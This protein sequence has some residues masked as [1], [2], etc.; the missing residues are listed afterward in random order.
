MSLDK[1]RL[2]E[3]EDKIRAHSD[4]E[5]LSLLDDKLDNWTP[6]AVT[7]ATSEVESRGGLEV[8]RTRIRERHEREEQAQQKRIAE[9]R[10]KEER[11]R[12]DQARQNRERQEQ[13]LVES[14]RSSPPEAESSVMK[15]YS[16]AYLVA[17][18]TTSIG[19]AVKTVGIGLGLLIVIAA[20][21]FGS[22][23]TNTIQAFIGGFILGAVAAIPIYV[24]GVLVSAHG[25]VLKATLDSAVHSSPFLKKEDMAKVMSL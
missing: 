15:R 21:I 12:Q 2:R 16:D 8:L 10:E 25:E 13:A 7:L 1:L 3:L 11:E 14:H 9:E 17:R 22:Q 24:L 4:S 23:A 5:L 6:E 20:V 19:V 18:A